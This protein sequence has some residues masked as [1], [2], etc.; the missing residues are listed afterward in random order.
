MELWVDLDDHT[1][2]NKE[3]GAEVEV[4]DPKFRE[5]SPPQTGLD[6]RLY[7]QPHR[8]VS[9]GGVEPCEL[10]RRDDPAE[11][12]GHGR[13]LDALAGVKEGHLIVECSREDRIDDHLARP[14]R[15]RPGTFP[16]QHADPV[17]DMGGEDVDHTHPAKVRQDVSLK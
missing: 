17:A 15:W 8:W 9:H 13:R 4:T 16:L 6:S 10:I 7:K 3:A 1:P 11:L 12:L 5:L 2:D 14:D